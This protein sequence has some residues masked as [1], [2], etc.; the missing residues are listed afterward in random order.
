VLDP[1]AALRT[2][3]RFQ[4]LHDRCM[5]EWERQCEVIRARLAERD[6]DTLLAP[7]I[8]VGEEE[9]AKQRAADSGK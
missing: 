9:K 6:L 7:L 1:F 3:P 4:K 2:D 5:A 8:A